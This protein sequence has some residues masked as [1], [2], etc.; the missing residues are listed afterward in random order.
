M[1]AT[2]YEESRSACM[3]HLKEELKPGKDRC[4]EGSL[5]SGIGALISLGDFDIFGEA[6][7]APVQA[8][9]EDYKKQFFSDARIMKTPQQMLLSQL[10]LSGTKASMA[11]RDW[12]LVRG[13]QKVMLWAFLSVMK[14]KKIEM[15][16]GIE[17]SA[18]VYEKMHKA[19]SNIHVMLLTLALEDALWAEWSK[20]NDLSYVNDR[21]SPD[22]FSFA[23]Q[24]MVKL[25]ATLQQKNHS[26]KVSRTVLFAAFLEAEQEGKFVTPKGKKGIRRQQDVDSIMA[27]GELL[28]EWHLFEEWRELEILDGIVT[29]FYGVQFATNFS[30]MVNDNLGEAAY[31]LHS[32]KRIYRDDP[33]GK[34]QLTKK[35]LLEAKPQKMMLFIKTLALQL[36]WAKNLVGSCEAQ[37]IQSQQ[38]M[39]Q[40][41]K[42]LK[43]V[44]SLDDAS[45]AT[46]LKENLLAEVKPCLHPSCADLID[47]IRSI[48]FQHEHFATFMAAQTL[49]KP[50]PQTLRND[51]LKRIQ[52]E[53]VLENWKIEVT[54]YAGDLKK[55]AELQKK[56]QQEIDGVFE[57]IE[58]DQQVLPTRKEAILALAKQELATYCPEY[59]LTG[60]PAR[61]RQAILKNP[62]LSKELNTNTA[63]WSSENQGNRRSTVFDAA[64]MSNPKH[65]YVGGRNQYRSKLGFPV[66]FFLF[67]LEVWCAH[68]AV[69]EEDKKANIDT[70]TTWNLDQASAS[71]K[72]KKALDSIKGAIW[73]KTGMIGLQH[74][75]ERRLFMSKANAL[76][77]GGEHHLGGLPGAFEECYDLH[78]GLLPERKKHLHQFGAAVDNLASYENVPLRNPTKSEPLVPLQIKKAVF[79]PDLDRAAGDN[80][81][82]DDEVGACTSQSY[83]YH[84][85]LHRELCLLV[86]EQVSWPP[87]WLGGGRGG[88]A[89]KI[90]RPPPLV[91]WLHRRGARARS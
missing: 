46:D 30:G 39:V 72:I 5:E 44:L 40:D 48:L 53:A 11:N 31:V 12:K 67:A 1:A 75:I 55:I 9:V 57:I 41:F 74:H 91:C 71:V 50:L 51:G 15:I 59:V 25:Q 24:F 58:D 43:E 18:E 16:Q 79:P 34:T 54:R 22:R 27:F 52:E 29:P 45:H 81:A 42:V 7:D 4:I 89:A 23:F 56:R 87:S 32:V 62:I 80:S 82:R 73:K 37:H 70:F 88:G 17:E 77:P 90:D 26:M 64:G 78:A 10:V 28:Q 69:T 20:Y 86:P 83:I 49:N 6:K 61:D 38:K 60:D 85:S 84:N 66:E 47:V 3:E 13:D 21:Y 19:S 63:T 65:T 8:D 33:Q 76:P 2:Y 14:K 35:K 36:A 68:S